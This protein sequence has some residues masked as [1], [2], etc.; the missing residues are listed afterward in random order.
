M[1]A[2]EAF[3]FRT[4][5]FGLLSGF[6]LRPSDFNLLST[7]S[8]VGGTRSL[9]GHHRRAQGMFRRAALPKRSAFG[10]L[11]LALENQAAAA[12]RG[13]FDAQFSQAQLP[14][15]IELGK[16]LAKP[17]TAAGNFSNSTP[18]SRKRPGTPSLISFCATRVSFR[19]DSPA[20]LILNRGLPALQL[21]DNIS[22][23]WRIFHRFEAGH[24]DR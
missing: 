18:P 10:R 3:G 11:E 15:G 16:S 13:F 12:I 14:L 7:I 24:Y 6:G 1:F 23:P 2:S 22:T 5:Y 19:A 17:Q 8:I 9:R 21:L 4:S 20:V